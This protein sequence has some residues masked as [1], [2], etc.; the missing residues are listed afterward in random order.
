MFW[1]AAFLGLALAA[2]P[3]GPLKAQSGPHD[4]ICYSPAETRERIRAEGL[5]DPIFVVRSTAGTIKADA[6]TAQLCRIDGRPFYEVSFLR[7][8]GRVMRVRIDAITGAPKVLS[9]PRR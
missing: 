2:D 5:V 6:L 4:R 1:L 9:G 8:D 7:D 3:V